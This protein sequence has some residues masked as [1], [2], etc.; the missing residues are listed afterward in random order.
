MRIVRE[1]SRCGRTEVSSAL[2][3]AREPCRTDSTSVIAFDRATRSPRTTAC[4]SLL[5]TASRMSVGGAQSVHVA[6]L[7][8]AM[9]WLR[10]GAALRPRA[11]L[12]AHRAVAGGARLSSSRALPLG[13]RVAPIAAPSPLRDRWFQAAEAP[14]AVALDVVPPT[15]IGGLLGARSSLRTLQHAG[16]SHRRPAP[17][18]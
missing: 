9:R 4:A 6:S 8:A 15:G 7:T 11:L 17:Q 16:V 3:E 1:A 2:A 13:Q 12:S 5:T 18:A 10:A 14:P